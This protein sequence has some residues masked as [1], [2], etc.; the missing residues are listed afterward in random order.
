ML[1]GY[2]LGKAAAIHGGLEAVFTQSYGPEARGGA[3][4]AQISISDEPIGYPHFDHADYLVALSQEAFDTYG[5]TAKSGA[6]VIVDDDLVNGSRAGTYRA[7][8]TRTAEELGARIVANVVMLGYV[9]ALTGIVSSEAMEEAIR[10][11]VR[12][13]VVDLNLRAFERGCDLVRA[14]V[15]S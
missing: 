6:T 4:A 9:T 12:D 7:P 2:L 8:F 11:E 3:C 5:P 10:T 14:E 13:K 1:A 15:A